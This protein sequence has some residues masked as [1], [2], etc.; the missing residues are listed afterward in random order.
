MNAEEIA[1]GLAHSKAGARADFRAGL[2][3]T[4]EGRKLKIEAHKKSR[5]PSRR[6]PRLI[7]KLEAEAFEAFQL[8]AADIEKFGP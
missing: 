6:T 1:A 3:A 4:F 5:D 7:E 2:V 8:L